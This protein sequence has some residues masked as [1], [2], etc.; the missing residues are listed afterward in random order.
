MH[1]GNPRTKKVTI[2][3]TLCVLIACASCSYIGA[4]QFAI[5]SEQDEKKTE[6]AS[7]ESTLTAQ[8]GH[9]IQLII[10]NFELNWTSLEAHTNP[11]IQRGLAT[12]PYLDDFAFERAGLSI[13]DDP[14]WSI[15]KSAAVTHLLVLEYNPDRFK[16]VAHVTSGIDRITP[17]GDFI[18]T[19]LPYKSCGIYVFVWEDRTWKLETYFD[20]TIPAD[21]Y[22]DWD[23]EPEWSRNSIG[24]LPYEAI[25]ECMDYC[26]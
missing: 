20:M 18:E 21:V 1:T 16:V 2:L 17:N 9:E 12:E 23:N 4:R 7:A 6:V 8:Y 26:K 13:Y 22:R 15:T 10:E 11:D 5:I 19:Y 25:H 14:F 24:D 3:I